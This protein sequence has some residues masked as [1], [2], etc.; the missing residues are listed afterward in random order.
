MT[1]GQGFANVARELLL[2]GYEEAM[3]RPICQPWDGLLLDALAQRL[4]ADR[5]AATS[6]QSTPPPPRAREPWAAPEQKIRR[7]PDDTLPGCA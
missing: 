7:I 4:P 1:W 5:L 2:S 3:V 6:G